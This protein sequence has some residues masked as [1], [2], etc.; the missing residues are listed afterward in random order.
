MR[1][2]ISSLIFNVKAAALEFA[3][4]TSDQPEPQHV[5]KR[6]DRNVSLVHELRAPFQSLVLQHPL[7][8]DHMPRTRP[9]RSELLSSSN[10]LNSVWLRGWLL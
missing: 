4:R 9:L 1:F 6:L 7:L 5:L 8:E 3:L 2:A 10:R